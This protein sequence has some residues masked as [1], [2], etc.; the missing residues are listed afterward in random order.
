MSTDLSRK[1]KLRGAHQASITQLQK[2]VSEVLVSFDPNTLE[3]IVPK[4]NQLKA[5]CPM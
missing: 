1:K 3:E 5:C 4:L 2:M